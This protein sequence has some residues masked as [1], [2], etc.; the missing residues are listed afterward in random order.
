MINNYF[1]VPPE[2]FNL[3]ETDVENNK[4]KTKNSKENKKQ[5]KRRPVEEELTLEDE[6]IVEK[7][8]P[9]VRRKTEPEPKRKKLKQRELDIIDEFDDEVNT[10]KQRENPKIERQNSSKSK[11]RK[12]TSEEENYETV[13]KQKEIESKKRERTRKPKSRR[14]IEEKIDTTKNA[15]TVRVNKTKKD[16]KAIVETH[17][18]QVLKSIE[19]PTDI[20]VGAHRRHTKSSKRNATK[21]EPAQKNVR[22]PPKESNTYPF[23]E[24]ALKG[25]FPYMPMGNYYDPY[26]YYPYNFNQYYEHRDHD[27]N[28]NANKNN[29]KPKN[30]EERENVAPDNNKE[31][32][33][34]MKVPS[35]KKI[36]HRKNGTPSNTHTIEI[37][38]KPKKKE[39]NTI[40]TEKPKEKVTLEKNDT[41]EKNVTLE[42]I[43]T[44]EKV[45]NS[46]EVDSTAKVDSSELVETTE[47][48]AVEKEEPH[49]QNTEDEAK[50]SEKLIELDANDKSVEEITEILME[51]PHKV[52]FKEVEASSNESYETYSKLENLLDTPELGEEDEVPTFNY[53]DIINDYYP[54]FDDDDYFNPDAENLENRYFYETENLVRKKLDRYEAP[55]SQRDDSRQMLEN[56]DFK[57]KK[58]RKVDHKDKEEATPEHEILK[59]SSEIIRVKI[60]PKNIRPKVENVETVFAGSKVAKYG[61]ADSIED[62]ISVQVEDSEESSDEIHPTYVIAK[63][64]GRPEDYY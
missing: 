7:K 53:N 5:N 64:V 1:I 61:L 22:T 50:E 10:R 35:N 62:I 13:D 6:E 34:K 18:G 28:N 16:R 38:L 24:D 9:V 2:F 26:S 25:F 42:N 51:K 36:Q 43:V 49:A 30:K 31:Q 4:G 60:P 12:N 3:N 45:Q 52:S 46:E 59:S 63:S 37:Q 29:K 56:P 41:S 14:V 32:K 39:N 54:R 58:V 15:E 40:S 33:R 17:N 48:V 19:K 44:A 57:T 47:K 20:P 11:P 8:T 23:T 55:R 21:K 27:R